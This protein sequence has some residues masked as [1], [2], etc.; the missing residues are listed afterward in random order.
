[1]IDHVYRKFPNHIDAIQAL[2]EKD[3]TFREICNDYEEMA[4]WLA[5]LCRSESPSQKECDLAREV[6]Q[7]LEAEINKWLKYAG[8]YPP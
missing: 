4:T 1:M 6:I 5:C 3:P 8:F 2:L 7:D